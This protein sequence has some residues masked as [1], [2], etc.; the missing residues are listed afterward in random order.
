MTRKAD[1]G[2]G[3]AEE[4]FCKCLFRLTTEP[5]RNTLRKLKH[6]NKS[7]IGDEKII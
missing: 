4:S 7:Q 3:A 1:W 6:L 5:L 2:G